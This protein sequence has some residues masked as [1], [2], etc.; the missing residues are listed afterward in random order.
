MRL[1]YNDRPVFVVDAMLGN[2]AKKLRLFGF[3]TKYQSDISD[4]LLIKEVLSQKRILITK[5]R[6]LYQKLKNTGI[7]VLLPVKFDETGILVELL[8]SCQIRQIDILPN[9]FT[10][11]TVCN[12]LLIS[13]NKISVIKEIPTNIFERIDIAY[14][15]S[16]CMKVYWSG[17]HIKIINNIIKEINCHL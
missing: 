3:D 15:C 17:T 9:S 1:P 16:N 12:G 5:D 2:I 11:C 10:R 7:K 13:V 6:R 4:E 8:K 14:R